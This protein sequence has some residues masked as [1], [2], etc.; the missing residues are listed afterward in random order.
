MVKDG[1]TG[2]FQSDELDD[3]C[4]TYWWEGVVDGYDS[5]EGPETALGDEGEWKMPKSL[6]AG[7]RGV[8]EL[9]TWWKSLGDSESASE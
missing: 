8:Q 5:R 9:G 4:E 2:E 1:V 3:R 7:V 6:M